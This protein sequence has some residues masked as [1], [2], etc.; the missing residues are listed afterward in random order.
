MPSDQRTHECRCLHKNKKIIICGLYGPRAAWKHIYMIRTHKRTP[1]VVPRLHTHMCKYADNK[2]KR[3]A[4]TCL[5]SQVHDMLFHIDAYASRAKLRCCHDAHATISASHCRHD[6]SL[7]SVLVCLE[8][9]PWCTCGHC[10]VSV[11][12]CHS[13]TDRQT[14]FIETWTDRQTSFIETWTDRQ[15]S[16]NR[17]TAHACAN[18]NKSRKYNSNKSREYNSNLHTYI[19]TFHKSMHA[20][21]NE[22]LKHSISQYASTRQKVM[23][24]DHNLEPKQADIHR[25][26]MHSPSSK[27]SFSERSIAFRAAFATFT[28]EGTPVQISLFS[29]SRCSAGD[30]GL[31]SGPVCMCVCVLRWVFSWHRYAWVYACL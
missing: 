1:I 15:T 31:S 16:F 23:C 27:T 25:I 24:F 2:R 21:R 5:L 13:D 17:V 22:S 19:H 14:S 4:R 26:Q 11:L 20:Y 28:G 18:S 30:L 3:D 12:K 6:V 29:N 9:L 8:L 7:V 10:F